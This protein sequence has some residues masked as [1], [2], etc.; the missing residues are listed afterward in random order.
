MDKDTKH[1]LDSNFELR[2]ASQETPINKTPGIEEYKYIFYGLFFI[3]GLINNLGL[4]E[5]I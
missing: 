5:L 3:M 2:S 4:N 1:L